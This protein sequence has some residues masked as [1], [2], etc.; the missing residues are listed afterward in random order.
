M[1][2]ITITNQTTNDQ[3]NL[4]DNYGDTILRDFQGFEYATVNYSI[5][6][7]AG[8]TGSVYI[9][10]KFGRRR[11][12]VTGDLIGTN[13]FA[14]RRLLA[15]AL[16][17]T[18]QMKLISFTTYDDL[19]LQCEAEIVRMVNPYNHKVHTFMLELVA[20]DW[21]FYSQTEK[22]Y[23]FAMAS[24]QGGVGIP[25]AIPMSFDLS[26]NPSNNVE[27]VVENSGSEYT[28]PIFQIYGSGTNFYV[29]N[30]TT[31]NSFSLATT[32]TDDDIVII[33]T[34][35]R[36]VIKNGS[37]NLYSAFSGDFLQLGVRQSRLSFIV[38]SG[39]SVNTQL[40]VSFRDAYTGI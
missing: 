5:D 2:Q 26:T 36:T 18:G 6:D 24:L 37:I 39:A 13:V 40:Y 35:N 33:D 4:Y 25:T 27:L 1:K 10:S 23:R 17:Q 32:L 3:F 12:T 21:R 7:I 30:E 29:G 14:N 9:N 8:I 11:F 34:K 15:N 22:T 28:E 16:R 31:G 38:E 20:P 19:Q